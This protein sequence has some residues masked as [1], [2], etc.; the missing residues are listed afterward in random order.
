MKYVLLKAS[1]LALSV[2]TLT[3]CIEATNY[4]ETPVTRTH[5]YYTDTSPH[6]NRHAS[7]YSTATPSAPPSSYSRAVTVSRRPIRDNN[8]Y[9]TA[10]PSAPPRETAAPP[11]STRS[12]VSTATPA[13]PPSTTATEDVA[14]SRSEE[15]PVSVSTATPAAPP[16]GYGSTATPAAPM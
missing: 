2:M 16:S 13:A 3:G 11:S 4:Y 7:Y 5:A 8:Y 9:S 12:Y 1:V 15:A 6:G 10:T 14:V